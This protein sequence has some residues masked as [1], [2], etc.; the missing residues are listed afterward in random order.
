[1][2]HFR[3]LKLTARQGAAYGFLHLL[4][5][6]MLHSDG[7]RLDGITSNLKISVT[8]LGQGK[9]FVS[10]AYR[11]VEFTQEAVFDSEWHAWR[12]WRQQR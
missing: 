6:V 4:A 3:E 11:D 9:D 8:M 5:L 1:V 12:S 2:Q 10:Q 7:N